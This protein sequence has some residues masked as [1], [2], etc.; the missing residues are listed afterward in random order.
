MVP[1]EEMVSKIEAALDARRDDA[2]VIVARTDA[3]AVEGF[4]AAIERAARYRDAGADLLF[5]EAPQSIEEMRAIPERVPGP[6]LVN[7]VQGGRTPQLPVRE[8]AMF[9]VVLWANIAL[10]AAMRGMC[11]VLSTLRET[12]DLASVDDLIVPWDVRQALVRKPEFDALEERF[13]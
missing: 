7:I 10:Q 12:G 1:V 5:I 4:D 6:H 9:D 8:L 11:D 3:R 2:T 13:A